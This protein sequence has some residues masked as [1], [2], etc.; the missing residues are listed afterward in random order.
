MGQR[1]AQSSEKNVQWVGVEENEC[2]VQ[3]GV[4]LSCQCCSRQCWHCCSWKCRISISRSFY[5]SLWILLTKIFPLSAEH[6]CR[7]Y[8]CIALLFYKIVPLVF[9]FSLI[10]FFLSFYDKCFSK[11]FHRKLQ[12]NQRGEIGVNNLYFTEYLS[13][14]PH[15]VDYFG[16]ASFKLKNNVLTVI[17]YLLLE[18]RYIIWK[19]W[20]SLTVPWS[21]HTVTLLWEAF[22][23][24]E[25][26]F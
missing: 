16:I 22:S 25:T 2:N 18:R 20:K 19:I 9:P 6:Y 5:V 14:I 21:M 23:F 15:L 24:L 12:V 26:T 7:N 10:F 11:G 3:P 17:I 1:E 13:A 8:A 4:S